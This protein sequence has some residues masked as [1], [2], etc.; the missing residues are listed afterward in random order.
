MNSKYGNAVPLGYAA[1]SIVLWMGMMMYA[2]W[3]S[4]EAGMFGGILAFTLGGIILGIAGIFSYLNGDAVDG[5]LFLV[6]AAFLWAISMASHHMGVGSADMGMMSAA[7]S[8][9]GWADLTWAVV[10][11]FIWFASMKAGLLKML[12]L[13]GFW[14]ALVI[15]TIAGWTSSEI[16]RVIGG[17]VGLVTAVIGLIYFVAESTKLGK[18]SPAS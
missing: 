11:F 17:Y 16:I 13:L 7:H 14:V 12:F 2:N 10:V 8:Y 3:Y 5:I 6:S 4:P 1:L 9:A 15:F 18:G